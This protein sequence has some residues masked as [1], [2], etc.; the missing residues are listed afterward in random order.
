MIYLDYAASTPLDPAVARAMQECVSLEAGL[1]N[2]SSTHA[3]GR[4]AAVRIARAREQV[5]ALLN[6]EAQEIVFTS[7][8]TESNNLAVLGIARASADRG[9]H[10]VSSRIEHRAVLDPCRQLQKEGFSVS[11]VAPDGAGRIPAEA[12][13]GA[14]R[15]DTCLVSVMHVNNETGVV[16]DIAGIGAACRERGIAFHSDAA[17]SVGRVPLDLAT[18]P[19][20]LLSVSAHKLYGPAGVGALYVRGGTRAL[21]KP[22]SFGGGQEAGLRPGTLATHQIVAFGAACELARAQL[23]REPERLAGLRERLWERLATLGRV[24]LNGAGALRAAH[25]LNVSFEGVDGESLVAALDAL[26]VSTG[27]ACSSASGDPSYVLK[28]LGRSSRLAESSLRFSLGRPTTAEEVERAA[29]EV[30]QAVR[31]LRRLSPAASRSEAVELSDARPH[32]VGAGQPPAWLSERAWGLFLGL[33]GAGVLDDA[34]GRVVRGEAGG[35]DA[36]CWIRFHLLVGGDTVKDARFQALGCPHTLATAAWLTTELRGRH[37]EDAVPGT[38]AM[39]AQ[40]LGVPVE[41]LGRL[42]TVEDALRS[43]I[44]HWT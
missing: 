20:D 34:A 16:Q 35:P 11:F 15:A 4:A 10:I 23:A 37:R 3:P 27:S 25:I 44:R 21:I 9:R 28:A 36:E 41:K 5:A 31:R 32:A 39:W 17:Q 7:G 6:C 30:I 12:V 29:D 26:A 22:L 43:C 42:L 18:L 1:G 38:P 14:L 33:P 2:P 40:A 13:S 19:V 24:H 8:A